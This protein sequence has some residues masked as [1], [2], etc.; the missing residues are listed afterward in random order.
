M[1]CSSASSSGTPV[2]RLP[3]GCT[4]LMHAARAVDAAELTKLLEAGADASAANAA[5]KTALMYAAER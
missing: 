4:D 3:D 1:A 5:G 2:A